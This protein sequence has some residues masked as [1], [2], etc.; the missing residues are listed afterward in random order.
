VRVPVANVLGDVDGGWAAARTVLS[1]ESAMI[2]GGQPQMYANLLRLGRHFGRDGDAVV[3]Q[4]LADAYTRE[5]LMAL[6]GE[7][8]LVAV[9]RREK[10]PIDPSIL[11]LFM[12]EYRVRAGELAA[13]IAG[14]NAM[15]TDD[16]ITRWIGAQVVG[17][18]SISIGGGTT[19]VQK[20]NLA[21]RALGLPR[22][23]GTNPDTPWSELPRSAVAAR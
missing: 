9:R 20:N 14:S 11:K 22:E 8:I 23:P 6:M 5:R 2:G 15:L 4:G 3:R 13:A 21:E 1:N 18:F 17:R 7:R 16:A 12:T 19:E 10:P